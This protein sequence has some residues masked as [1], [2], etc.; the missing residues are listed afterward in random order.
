VNE[1]K[2]YYSEF[3]RHCLRFYIK[4]L[5]EG[6]GGHPIFRSDAERENWRACNDAMEN[7][8]ERDMGIV[9]DLYRPGDTIA[10]KIYELSKSKGIPQD[11]IWSLVNRVE[12]AVAKRRG[13]V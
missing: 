2:P 7:L 10:D 11:T 1:L 9:S 3:V 6:K 5:D 8:S 4:T 13:L 12:R